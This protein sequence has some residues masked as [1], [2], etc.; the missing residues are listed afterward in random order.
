VQN[1]VRTPKKSFATQYAQLLTYRCGAPNRRFGPE[2]DMIR[3]HPLLK[4]PKGN[5]LDFAILG[6]L[7][8]V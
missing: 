3:G 8:H 5:K 4:K 7:G 1:F 6:R 2:T